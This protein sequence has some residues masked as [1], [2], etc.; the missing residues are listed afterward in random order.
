[1]TLRLFVFKEHP[2]LLVLPPSHYFKKFSEGLQAGFLMV[3]FRRQ[4]VPVWYLYFTHRVQTV[5][6]VSKIKTTQNC[7]KSHLWFYSWSK[8]LTVAAML[9][10]VKNVNRFGILPGFD[11]EWK[12][13]LSLYKIFIE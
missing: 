4:V 8:A 12:H 5:Q 2:D 7:W 6:N 9:Q 3:R 13:M 11:F 1:M 10:K